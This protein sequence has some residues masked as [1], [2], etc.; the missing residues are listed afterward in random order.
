[1]IQLGQNQTHKVNAWLEQVRSDHSL[2]LREWEII[3]LVC[4]GLSN[5]EI[6]RRLDLHEGTVKVH[7]HNIYTKIGIPNRTALALWG[8]R[9][10]AASIL[11]VSSGAPPS[12]IPDSI[13]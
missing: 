12:M 3:G 5:K 11:P 13:R 6:A 7:L 4:H 8:F 9:A 1:M 2:T 10:K